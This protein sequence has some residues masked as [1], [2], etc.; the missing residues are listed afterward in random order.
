[1]EREQW[2]GAKR[3]GRRWEKE[4]DRMDQSIGRKVDEDKEEENRGGLTLSTDS[5]DMGKEETEEETAQE[6]DRDTRG[7]ERGE[8]ARPRRG[9]ERYKK[10]RGFRR[11][12]ADDGVGMRRE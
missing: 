12:R 9:R 3:G 11:G 8:R 10:E 1:M 2:R 5:T 7:L 4:T 6:K